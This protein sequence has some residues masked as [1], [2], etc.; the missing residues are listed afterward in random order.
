MFCLDFAAAFVVHYNLASRVSE[1]T[2]S[3]CMFTFSSGALAGGLSAI[4]LYP[5]DFVRMSTVAPGTSH[6]AF[7]T[8]PFMSIYLGCYFLQPITDRQNKPLANKVCWAMAATSLAAVVETP[9]DRA[10]ISMVGGSLRTAAVASALRVP[11][12]SALLL[13]YDQI[14]SAAPSNR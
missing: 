14:L 11:L 9:F 7:G 10:K 1:S 5:F 6:F 4:V 2:Q 12:G 13:A 8:V 3:N